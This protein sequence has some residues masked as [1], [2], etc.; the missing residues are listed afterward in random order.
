MLSITWV[1]RVA[2]TRGRCPVHSTCACVCRL[3][4]ATCTGPL[5]LH[6]GTAECAACG[7]WGA[8]QAISLAASSSSGEI[9]AAWTL[10]PA[11]PGALTVGDCC[12]N[13]AVLFPGCACYRAALCAQ[14]LHLAPPVALQHS[15]PQPPVRRPVLDRPTRQLVPCKYFV[16]SCSLP[17]AGMRYLCSTVCGRACTALP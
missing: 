16:M 8:R 15:A 7:N 17:A 4:L 10:A 9:A 12:W 5:L 6:Q 13:P 3:L 2:W 11:G 14:P 1:S